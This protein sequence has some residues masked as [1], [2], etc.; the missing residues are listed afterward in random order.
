MHLGGDLFTFFQQIIWIV[1]GLQSTKSSIWGEHLLIHRQ[2]RY[3]EKQLSACMIHMVTCMLGS[4]T[5]IATQI[6]KSG[7]CAHICMCACGWNAIFGWHFANQPLP[8]SGQAKKNCLWPFCSRKSHAMI[9]PSLLLRCQPICGMVTVWI[10][11]IAALTPTRWVW[12]CAFWTS[13]KCDYQGFSFDGEFISCAPN[14]IMKT[15]F[16]KLHT[17]K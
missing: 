11:A 6:C 12:K 13:S 3:Y 16:Q 15:L 4:L 14:V 17:W 7:V 8:A 5:Q 10:R 1:N 2:E 9:Q